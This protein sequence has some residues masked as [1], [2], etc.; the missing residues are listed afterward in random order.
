MKNKTK[1]MIKNKKICQR[2]VL[3]AGMGSEMKKKKVWGGD[4][5]NAIIKKMRYISFFFLLSYS[6]Y[7]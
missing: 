7:Y 4:E 5:K 6:H 2:V 3:V 1:R